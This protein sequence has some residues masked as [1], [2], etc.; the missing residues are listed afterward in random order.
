MQRCCSPDSAS[1]VGARLATQESAIAKPC[2]FFCQISLSPVFTKETLVVM[3]PAPPTT[4]TFFVF[5]ADINTSS[6][7]SGN[8]HCFNQCVN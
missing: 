3:P 8:H 4:T 5:P 7:V 2:L 6:Q 1:L